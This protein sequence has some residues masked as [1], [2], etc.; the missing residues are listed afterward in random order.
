MGAALEAGAIDAIIPYVVPGEAA[1]FYPG[2][3]EDSYWPVEEHPVVIRD[4]RAIAGRLRL[5]ENGFVVVQRPTALKDFSD[6]AQIKAIYYPEIEALVKS[7]TGATRVLIFGEIIRTDA[8]GTPDSRLPARG[9]HV[10][11]DEATVQWWTRDLVGG[12]EAERLLGH[13]HMLM[14]LWRPITTVEKTPLALCD[15]S[16]VERGDLN[17]SEIRG[18][19]DDPNRRP[20]RGFNIA[21][22]PRHRW[23]YVPRMRPDEIFAFKLCDSDVSRVQLTGH[24][25]FD[26]PTSAPDARPR[27]SIEIRTISFFEG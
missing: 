17:P 15:A 23:Y 20:M 25:A 14:N 5:E 4:A 24:T 6:P 3:R 21:Y 2:R 13:R 1:I 9:A 26:D 11:Y 22:S 19:L 27:Q 8:K 7:L 16:T 12:A 10:D 18:G